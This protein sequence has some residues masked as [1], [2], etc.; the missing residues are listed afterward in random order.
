M[1]DRPCPG[2]GYNLRGLETGG[3]CPECGT[4]ITPGRKHDR[5]IDGLVDAPRWYIRQIALAMGMMAAVVVGVILA[6]LVFWISVLPGLVTLAAMTVLAGVW[7]AASWLATVRRPIEDH[8]VPDPILDHDRLR[9]ISRWSQAAGLFVFALVWLAVMTQLRL[10]GVLA[11]LAS[12]G[13]LFGLVPLGVY[14]SALADWSGD[15]AV[16]GRLRAAVWCI[17]VC[18]A[19]LVVLSGLGLVGVSL[20]F[21]VPVLIPIVSIIVMVGVGMFGWSVIQLSISAGWAI[22]NSIEAEARRVRMEEKR[23]RRA[24]QAAERTERASASMAEADQRFEEA[25]DERIPEAI[26]LSDGD[27]QPVEPPARPAPSALGERKIEP[28]SD[29]TP[30]ELAPE[31]E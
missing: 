29:A 25:M 10:F 11:G 1:K 5:L 23:R 12:L 6:W 28:G 19:L 24:E 20:G 4:P 31:D 8:T 14:L 16:G 9:T 18:G 13:V 21:V 30:Y 26:P 22:Q 15:T 17:A 2:C 27:A 3:R 7:F